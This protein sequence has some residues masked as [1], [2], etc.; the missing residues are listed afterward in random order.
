MTDKPRCD[1]DSPPVRYDDAGVPH[2]RP[3][4]ILRSAKGRAEITKAG[5]AFR[6]VPRR[7]VLRQED[8]LRQMAAPGWAPMGGLLRDEPAQPPSE[9][10]AVSGSP[11]DGGEK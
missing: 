4:D 10:P 5:E 3:I 6:R 8:Y 2:V 11:L 1:F 9:K 7:E